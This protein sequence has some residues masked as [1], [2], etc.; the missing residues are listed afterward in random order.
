VT[1]R[2][3]LL[4]LALLMAACPGAVSAPAPQAAA[5]PEPDGPRFDVAIEAPASAIAGKA[6]NA[7][8]VI[9]PRA[10]WH[11]NLDYSPKL[12][13][14]ATGG[15]ELDTRERRGPDA[16]RFDADGLTFDLPFTPRDKGP[17]RIAGELQF[18]VCGGESCAPQSVP[19]DFTVD[20]GCDTDALC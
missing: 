4:V 8:I 2:H 10:P 17:K 6:S 16:A 7:R 15:V 11:V 12:R 1:D 20:V 19:V 3:T 13:I 9:S 18:A 14:D 5:K